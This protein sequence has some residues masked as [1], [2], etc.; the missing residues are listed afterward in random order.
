MEWTDWK[1][2]TWTDEDQWWHSEQ[3]GWNDWNVESMQESW[4]ANAWQTTDW[5]ETSWNETNW[6]E[7][8]TKQQTDGTGKVVGSLI[9]SPVLHVDGCCS[10][11]CQTGLFLGD[12]DC[13][14]DVS[15]S[16]GTCVLDHETVFKTNNTFFHETNNS[17]LHDTSFLRLDF[18]KSENF[19]QRLICLEVESVMW[20]HRSRNNIGD[21]VT[22]RSI[23]SAL[24]ATVVDQFFSTVARKRVPKMLNSKLTSVSLVRQVR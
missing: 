18:S 6:D 16:F 9:L 14:M 8:Q 15:E 5:N 21:R 11:T 3:Y 24:N 12:S 23:H 2:E 4:N 13:E 7:T 19:R 20:T 22:C 10:E 17:F 1:N